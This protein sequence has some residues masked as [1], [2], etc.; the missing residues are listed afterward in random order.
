MWHCFTLIAIPFIPFGGVQ[1]PIGPWHWKPEIKPWT[2]RVKEQGKTQGTRLGWPNPH[3]DLIKVNRPTWTWWSLIL[4]VWRRWVCMKV[5]PYM[6]ICGRPLIWFT[7]SICTRP[8]GWGYQLRPSEGGR[9]RRWNIWGICVG[10]S[11]RIRCGW[12]IEYSLQTC[13]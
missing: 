3:T 8:L 12:M 11:W 10:L 4:S 2:L 7:T 6:K 5:W 1:C 9:R 13:G